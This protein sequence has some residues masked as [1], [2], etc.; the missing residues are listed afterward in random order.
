MKKSL[1]FNQI[2]ELAGSVYTR[3]VNHCELGEKWLVYANE[4]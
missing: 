3:M 4:V 2:F 1:K